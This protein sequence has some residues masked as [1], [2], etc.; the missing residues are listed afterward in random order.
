LRLSQ[1]EQVVKVMHAVQFATAQGSHRSEVIL[2][3][4]LDGQS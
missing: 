1:T 4:K 3:N 2:I